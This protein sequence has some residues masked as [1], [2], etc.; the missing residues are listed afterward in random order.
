MREK[1][2]RTHQ[3]NCMHAISK[4]GFNDFFSEF[5]ITLQFGGYK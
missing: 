2:I 4:I 5:L 3:L 1:R